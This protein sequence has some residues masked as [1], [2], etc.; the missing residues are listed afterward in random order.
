[1]T[2]TRSGL[3]IQGKKGMK[4]TV[5]TLFFLVS[6]AAVGQSTNATLNEDY[7]HWIDR[8]EIKSGKIVPEIFTTIKPYKR[9]AIIRFLD[10]LN[11]QEGIF[12]SKS[13]QF[14]LEYLRN[15]S[16]EWSRAETS[17]SKKPFLK[18]LYKKK[19]DLVYVD[20]PEFDLH[21]NPVLY[22][23]VGNDTRRD[24]LITNNTRGI[25][26][27]GMID[28]K[29]GFYTFVGENQSVLPMYVQEDV[30][31]NKVVPHEGF[32]KTFKEN[33]VDYFQARAYIDFNISKHIYMQF[34]NDRT[35]TGNGYRSFI[36]SDYAP[37]NFYLRAN[38][39]VWK[40]NYRYQLNRM[41][42]DA[43][44]SGNQRYPEKFM[45]HHHA[46]FNIGKKLNIGIF[47]SVVFSP[48]D[49]INNN[50]FD[51]SYLNPVIFY[52]AI[53]QQ[54]GSSDN[55]LLGLD[56]KWNAF[57]GVSFYGQLVLDEFLLDEI[58]AGDGWWANKYA[59]QTGVKYIDAFTVSNLDVQAEFNVVR[60]YTFSH[61][62][63]YG[64]YSNYRQP[65]GHP[66]GANFS[67]WVG[68]VRY[69]PIARLNLIAKVFYADIGRDDVGQNWGSDILKNSNTREQEYG[70]TIGQGNANTILFADFTASYMLKHN[71]FIDVKQIVRN[72]KSDLP[73]YNS[74]TSL[75]SVALRWNMPQ[76]LYDF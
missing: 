63:Q 74:N 54:F 16:W 73:A 62:S 10:T 52:R 69:Q 34:G 22:L 65:I 2:T 13:D 14:N 9:D 38:V 49:S 29:V 21:V 57:R 12:D 45:V 64:S 6:V 61:Y 19:S 55:A 75:T 26:I 37:P 36:L 44:T 58:K 20:K 71:F 50:T 67:E 40:L 7:Y 59:I 23:S 43:R 27:R 3:K 1:M 72:S 4:Y 39:K 47:E 28:R 31:N 68:I 66:L 18:A 24:A 42:A 30:D 5:A 35:F 15:D 33:G 17:D 8:Y 41:A 56:I 25:E 46:S 76:R 60:P 32:W 48:K 51:L 70:N 11:T 53:E